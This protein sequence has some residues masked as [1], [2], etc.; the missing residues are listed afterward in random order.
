MTAFPFSSTPARTTRLIVVALALMLAVAALVGP[1]AA[2][3]QATHNPTVTIT[4]D[5]TTCTLA[6]A[7]TAANT[8]IATGGCPAG[9]GGDTINVTVDVTLTSALPTI[10]SQII[11]N[12]NDHTIARDAAAPAFRILELDNANLTLNRATIAGGYVTSTASAGGAGLRAKLSTLV[13]NNSTFRDNEAASPDSSGALLFGGFPDSGGNT[14]TI[15]NSTIRGNSSQQLSAVVADCSYGNTTLTIN[16]S[17]ISGNFGVTG[18]VALTRSFGNFQCQ[19]T[20]ESSTITNNSSTQQVT[21][22]A[23]LFVSGSSPAI[24]VTVRNSIIA[25]QTNAGDCQLLGSGVITSGGHNISSDASCNFTSTG[26]QE[27]VSAA[28]LLLGPLADNGGDTWTHA[29]LPGSVAINAGDTSLTTDQRGITRPQGAADDVGAYEWQTGEG[30]CFYTNPTTASTEAELNAAIL[31]FSQ[32]TIPGTYQLDL[33]ADIDLTASSTEIRNLTSDVVLA[34]DGGGYTVDGQDIPG[35]R[36]F[37]VA[38]DTTATMNDLTVSGGRGIGDL[39]GGGILNRGALT[40]SNSTISGNNAVSGGGIYNDADTLTVSNSTISSNIG[41]GIYND[42]ATLTVSNSTIDANTTSASGG[43]IYT[44]RN[45]SVTITDSTISG[46][47]ANDRGGGISL[48]GDGTGLLPSAGTL[49]VERSTISGN[50]ATNN[51]GGIE[52]YLAA[53]QVTIANSTFS[54]NTAGSQ[55]GGIH[56]FIFIGPTVEIVSSTFSGNTAGTGGGLNLAAIPTAVENTIIANST[57]GDCS[58]TAAAGSSNNLIEDSG[59]ACGLSNGSNGNI[60]GQDPNLGALANNGGPTQT[61]ALLA[62]SPAINAGDTTLT[63]D[64]RGYGRPAGG[65]DDIGAYEYDATPLAITLAS[66]DA[67]AQA[68]HVLVTWETVSELENSGFNLY[69]TDTAD[70]PAAANLLAFVP[71]QGPGSAQGFAYSYPDY[72]VTAGQ[73]YWYWLEDVDFS[74]YVTMHGPVSVVFVA[75]TAVTLSGLEAAGQQ[76]PLPV[77]PVAL[78]AIAALVV[79]GG[80]QLRRRGA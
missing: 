16:N 55:G 41:G 48:Y 73:T 27:N 2:S 68:D 57:G 5:G 45:G 80:L 22:V 4:V 1:T 23:G 39:Y 25:G 52:L 44:T 18:G 12:G 21:S 60:V 30:D 3:A 14:V 72:A 74:G 8:D 10:T 24:T 77:W 43:G 63:T 42:A 46:N 49:T 35:V 58:G 33:G 56:N 59:S 50:T 26:D 54:G 67:A 70:P 79:A 53:G 78:A 62:G 64:Q 32:Q 11:L 17:T 76:Q 37:A 29:L 20:I 19:A 66:F 9:S 61:H 34:L 13:V 71:S 47:T 38:A 40:V 6:D 51:G 75:P 28:A 15:N 69:R 7:I 31:C 65:T 36:P